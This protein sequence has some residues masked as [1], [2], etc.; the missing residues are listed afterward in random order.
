MSE[1]SVSHEAARGRFARQS[2]YSLLGKD[3]SHCVE[4]SRWSPIDHVL[5][6]DPASVGG[7]GATDPLG[8]IT[9]IVAP[10]IS[11]AACSFF[12]G[13]PS[14][15]GL[16]STPTFRSAKPSGPFSM[17]LSAG[18]AGRSSRGR[19][20]ASAGSG[21]FLIPSL[22]ATRVW[23]I[24]GAAH[25]VAHRHMSVL[26]EVVERAFRCVDRDMCE[27]GAAEPFQLRVE[28]G[29]LRPCSSGS[30]GLFSRISYA[31]L[32]R[33]GLPAQILDLAAGGSTSRLTC[34]SA[35]AGLHELFGP[36][37]I[38]A[39][40]DAFLAAQLGYAALTAQAVQHDP[41]LVFSREMSAVARRISFNTCSAGFLPLEDLVAILVP[42][43]CDETKTLLKS[44]PQIW[45]RGA[46]GEQNTTSVRFSNRSSFSAWRVRPC[47]RRRRPQH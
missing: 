28:I 41:D 24:V 5:R 19:A 12:R 44:Q 15:P 37:V 23:L 39:L 21:S 30:S 13:V 29:E 2:F 27:V 35:L 47:S 4:Q 33:T 31:F 45:D 36:S 11:I 40:R 38:Q 7:L 10:S 3:H 18:D 20:A 6:F 26:L 34:Q 32:Q 43:S 25:R 16:T 42:S 22:S 1:K 46:D 17:M 8:A 14:A 9:S